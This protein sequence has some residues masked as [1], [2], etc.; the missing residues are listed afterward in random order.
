MDLGVLLEFPRGVSPPLEWRHARELSYLAVAAVSCF[1][2]RGSRDLWHS[3]EAFPRGLPSRLSHRAEGLHAYFSG[4]GLT[5]KVMFEP[6]LKEE[7]KEYARWIPEGTAFEAEGIAR[8]NAL[9]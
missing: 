5:E 9:R 7:M 6:D 1:P 4:Q 3:L 8:T 2:S